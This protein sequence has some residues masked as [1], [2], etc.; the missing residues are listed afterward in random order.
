MSNIKY[1]I[2]VQP[3]NVGTILG[4]KKMLVLHDILDELLQQDVQLKLTFHPIESEQKPALKDH[5]EYHVKPT[6][7]FSPKIVP[8]FCG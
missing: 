3:Q 1:Q 2:I 6:F 4:E 8:T 5:Q 7:F